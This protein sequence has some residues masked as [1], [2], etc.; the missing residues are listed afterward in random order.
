MKANGDALSTQY[1]SPIFGSAV[2]V[3]QRSAEYEMPA[4]MNIGIGYAYRFNKSH[5]LDF[6]FNFT[7]HSFTYDQW[8]VG[9][10]YNWKNMLMVRGG[11]TFEEGSFGNRDGATPTMLNAFVGPTAGFTFESPLKK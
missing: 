1:T 7:T 2:T 8:M 4:L 5:T 3:E 10:Q 6:A 11:Y 9:V